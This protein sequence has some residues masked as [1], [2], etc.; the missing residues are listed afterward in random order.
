MLKGNTPVFFLIVSFLGVAGAVA[1]RFVTAP[2]DWVQHVRELPKR[3]DAMQGEVCGRGLVV[4]TD[5]SAESKLET[6]A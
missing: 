1:L 2:V 5:I 6:L 3:K 4:M